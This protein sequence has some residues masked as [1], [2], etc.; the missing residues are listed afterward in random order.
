M[1][2]DRIQEL[3]QQLDSFDLSKRKDTLNELLEM[4]NSGKIKFAKTGTDINLHIHSFFSYN[5]CGYSPSKIAWLG[6]K[7]G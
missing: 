5:A 3:E 7:R 1:S 6:Q 4:A 2:D